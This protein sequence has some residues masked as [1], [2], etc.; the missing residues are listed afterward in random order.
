MQQTTTCAPRDYVPD[1]FRTDIQALRGLAV[2][3]VVLDHF[4][5]GPFTQGYLGVD[6]FFVISGFLITKI[7]SRDIDAGMF[8]FLDFY[9]RRARRILPAAYATIALTTFGSIWFLNSVEFYAL[10]SQVL[11]ALTYTINFVLLEQV[12]YFDVSAGFK[13]LLHMWSLAVEEQFYLL[14]PVFL[15]F[16]PARFRFRS[17]GVLACFSFVACLLLSRK[18]TAGTFYLLPTRAWELLVGAAGAVLPRRIAPPD[19][20]SYL[21]FPS[22]IVVFALSIKSTGLPHPGA[23]AAV[24]CVAT[25][26]IIL[27]ENAWLQ[28]TIPVKL[29]GKVGD[30]S[31]SLYLVHWPLIVFLNSTFISPPL[32]RTRAALL[33]VAVLFATI[34]YLLVERPFLRLRISFLR[35]AMAAVGAGIILAL[36]QLGASAVGGRLDFAYLR[37]PNYGLDRLCD[38]YIFENRTECRTKNEPQTLVWGDSYGMFFASGARYLLKEG[39]VQATYSACP[40]FIGYAPYN[41]AYPDPLL[42]SKYCIAFNDGVK[43]YATHSQSLRTVIIAASFGQYTVSGYQMMRRTEDG[44]NIIEGSNLETAKADLRQLVVDLILAGKNVIVVSPPPGVDESTVTCSERLISHKFMIGE[45]VNCDNAAAP[46]RIGN[47]SIDA[48]LRVAVSAGAKE[49]RWADGMCDQE[50]CHSI[51]DGVAL[52]R[53]VGHLSYDGAKEVLVLMAKRRML[54]SPFVVPNS[55]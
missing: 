1:A 29:L 55:Q 8:S 53:D 17:I 36:A 35:T 21:V 19:W 26:T 11:G 4:K 38:N 7:I 5:L 48:L 44:E 24:I 40:P 39:M 30:I 20:A 37:R 9:Q 49:I 41:P 14:F 13:P 51:L 34:M 2:A 32:D 47:H 15:F 28:R 52:Y 43:T 54:P 45:R 18:Y 22:L 42:V 3:L 6:I 31:Y 33:G 50:V 46:Y 27:A 23:D 16:V 25:L 10:T 12:G